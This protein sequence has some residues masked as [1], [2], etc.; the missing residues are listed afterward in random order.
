MTPSRPETRSY[1]LLVRFKAEADQEKTNLEGQS[2]MASYIPKV[3]K[4][5]NELVFS[6]F[7]VDALLSVIRKK[8]IKR[9]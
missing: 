4:T 1:I 5:I 8:I 9:F 6:H 3:E 2:P 7:S